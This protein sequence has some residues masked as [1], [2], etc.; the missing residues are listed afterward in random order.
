MA[1]IVILSGAGISAESG[2]HTFRDS[3]GLW[4]KYNIKDICTAGSLVS[5]RAQTL[6]FYDKR[7]EDIKDKLPNK[8][9]KILAELKN[10]YK[11]DIA[12]IT[13][14]V[15]NLFEKAGLNHD[16][17]IHLH[18]YLTN[19]KCEDCGFVY[20]IGYQKINDAFNGKCPTCYCKNIRPFIVMFGEMA[21]N[22]EKLY[23]ELK[24]CEL[25]I[26]IGTSGNVVEV[27]SMAKF[28]NKSILNNLEQSDVIE[29]A[30]FSKVIYKK[31]SEAIDEIKEDI[32]EFFAPVIYNRNL[33]S[34][35]FSMPNLLKKESVMLEGSLED[36]QKMKQRIR[37][38]N[39]K[40]FAELMNK[41]NTIDKE[42]ALKKEWNEI[43]NNFVISK[44]A[45]AY[46]SKLDKSFK[47]K[48]LK[49]YYWNDLYYYEEPT[50][51][52]WTFVKCKGVEIKDKIPYLITETENINLLGSLHELQEVFATP[53]VKSVLEKALELC[54][55]TQE[56]EDIAI[57]VMKELND[58]KWS[59]EIFLKAIEVGE[60]S[61]SLVYIA[62]NIVENIQ[63]FSLAFDAI[64]KAYNI[65]ENMN[66][67]FELLLQLKELKIE[68]DLINKWLEEYELNC[69]TADDFLGLAKLKSN[70][71][72]DAISKAL[73]EAKDYFQCMEILEF[74]KK[75][76]K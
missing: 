72:N 35:Y 62:K 12:I 18:G 1:K 32:E 47:N 61:F 43:K 69:K 67:F 30:L 54:T 52:D 60:D 56:L 49:F 53:T 5:N 66:D 57:T 16:D 73:I 45:I 37:D 38:T 59:K 2:I 68:N 29:D 9:H 55:S 46:I 65:K 74:I 10:R 44:D 7:R 71:N 63:D 39:E 4:N 70:E 51:L 28:I 64:K 34:K 3:G 11:N 17:V 31:A 23:Y 76:K 26:V 24:D 58:S 25:F 75:S 15:D 8:A 48:E 41:H 20:D 13:Q 40:K 27:N 42:E 21:P 36:Y 19:V 14:N 6:E 22:Y 33:I 50:A